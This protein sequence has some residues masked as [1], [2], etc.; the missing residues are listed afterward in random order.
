MLS[1]A[2]NRFNYWLERTFVRGA[3]YRLLI[4]AALI[5]LISI[6]GGAVVLALGTGHGDL[7]EAVWWA[8][9]RLSDP[10]YLGDDVGIVNRTVSTVI[11]IVGYVVF[12]GALVAVMT[13]WLNARM[14]SLESGLTPVARNNHILILGWT[15]RTEAIVRELLLSEER[16]RRFL[17]RHGTRDLHIAVMADEVNAT[18]AQD[19]RDAVGDARD[20]QKVT[21]RSGT[22]LDCRPIRATQV[23]RAEPPTTV[24]PR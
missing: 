22:A 2:W 9:L 11:T 12:L 20:E 16:V 6:V 15:N 7:G 23:S 18:R 5:G 13:Q 14:E 17:R 4:V 1:R 21:L 19:L 10:G 3:Q 24:P 8:F